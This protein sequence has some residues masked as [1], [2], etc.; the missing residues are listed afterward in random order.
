MDRE[1][2]SGPTPG[3]VPAE[4]KIHAGRSESTP[5]PK[6]RFG[7]P[8]G[9]LRRVEPEDDPAPRRRR[10][11]PGPQGRPSAPDPLRGSGPEHPP[12]RGPLPPD[13]GGSRHGQ[14]DD[15]RDDRPGD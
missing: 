7:R 12:D 9:D 11:G 13:T 2:P 6:I 5:D 10:E 14:R 4:A 3:H 15:D 8:D 1:G